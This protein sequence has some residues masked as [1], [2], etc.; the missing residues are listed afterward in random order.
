MS[1]IIHNQ[2]SEVSDDQLRESVRS[3]TSEQREAFDVV[4]SWCRD[5][6]KNLNSLR[7][8]AVKPIYL[9][10]S[11]GGGCGKS[12]LI[13]TIYHTVTKTF[14]YAPT[15]LERPT[16]LLMAPTGVA[17][18]NIEGTTI[19]SALAIPKNAGYKLPAMSDPKKTQMRLLLSELKLLIIDEISM[20]S[21]VTLLHIHQRLQEIFGTY[22][23]LLFGGKS[24]IAVGDLFQLEPIRSKPVFENYKDDTLNICHPW[25]VFQMIE[26]R[27]VMRQKDDKRFTDLLNR[28]RVGSQSD[29][30]IQ[31]IQ[32]R[33]INSSDPNY[34][35][36][37]LHI[38]AENN[39]VN[40]YNNMRLQEINKPLF[41]L[42]A[43]DQYPANVSEQEIENLL[44]RQRS[45]TGGLDFEIS[46]K[47]TA[48][49]MLTTNIDI[50][51]RL[52]NGQLGT[53][54]RINVSPMTQKPTIIYIK[55][56][57][58]KAGKN[59]INKSNNHFAKKNNFVPIEPI[60]ARFKVTPEKPSSPE[61][62]RVQFPITLAWACTVHKV[63]GLTLDK[64]VVSLS[65]NGQK[66][67]NYGQIYVAIS[68]CKTLEGMHIL[69]DIERKHVR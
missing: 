35:H 12:F 61:I 26:L 48:R 43:T 56:D 50:A 60:L 44:G 34:P 64:I 4:F 65:L 49:V 51:D 39:P 69:G 15:N 55:F 54:M 17:A 42:R 31:L 30:D 14:R 7:P 24:I 9:F 23:S 47:E 68:L 19:N 38:W 40:Q 5:S 41:Y 46:V 53:I 6:M 20:V 18:I 3:L 45:D 58:S 37:V 32:S 33:S 11:G 22:G 59:V 13:K 28:L 27:K 21:N 62:Q 29:E 25:H 36:D 2:P 1:L 8:K 10:L 67:F 16:V 66:Y 63:Q 57:D 52:I